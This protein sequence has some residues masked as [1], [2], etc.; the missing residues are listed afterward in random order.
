MSKPEMYR[1][2]NIS[3]VEKF[4]WTIK[5]QPGKFFMIDKHSLHIDH[6]YQREAN[7]D[8]AMDAAREWSWL[9]CG[10]IIVARRP[11]GFWVIDGQHRVLASRHRA[12]IAALPC[13]VFECENVEAEAKGFL[14]VNTSRR[15]MSSIERFHAS[16]TAGDETA[17]FVQEV[18]DDLGIAVTKAAVHGKQIKGVRVCIEQ[19]AISRHEFLVVMKFVARLCET[20]PL[21]ERLLTALFFLNA[22]VEGGV[23]DPRMRER[24]MKLGPGGIMDAT[25]KAAAYY[26]RGGAKIWAEGIL[27]EVNRGLRHRFDFKFADND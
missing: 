2:T 13:L 24:L 22:N 18:F 4:G 10:A 20:T 7:I 19:A 3:K 23:S 5:D 6:S 25:G 26:S 17:I 21:Y 16:I 15:P 1:T 9:A 14:N 27:N 11:A 8:K 12:D